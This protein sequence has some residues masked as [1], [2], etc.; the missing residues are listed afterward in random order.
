M[1]IDSHVH[2]WKFDKKRD[3]WITD[4]MKIL[5][6]DYLPSHLISTLRRNGV[7][8]CVA[9]QAAQQELETHFLVELARTYPEIKGV[10]GWIDLRDE[11]IEERL[12]YFS[13]YKIIRG[14]RHIVQ[15]EPDGFLLNEKF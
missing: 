4:K 10:V 14:W 3:S 1:I 8:A 5:R 13:Q 2:F 6:Q 11:R 7:D 9:V 12:D 15:A